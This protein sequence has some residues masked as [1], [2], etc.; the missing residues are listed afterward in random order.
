MIISPA[1]EK[2][3]VLSACEKLTGFENVMRRLKTGERSAYSELL[4]A[5][6]L[7]KIGFQPVL[8]PRS[9]SGVLDTLIPT[10][11][12]KVYCEVIAPETSDAIR[13]IKTAASTLA[14]TLKEQNAGRRVE[15]LLL[16]DFDEDSANR[17]AEAVKV[18]PDSSEIWSLGID[19]LPSSGKLFETHMHINL[20]RNRSC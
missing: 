8:E 15:V 14:G 19:A 10:S 12:G 3:V 4:F 5:A 16:V 18:R 9:G 7:V 6:R 2:G 13:E 17:V 11:T 1:I 20:Y